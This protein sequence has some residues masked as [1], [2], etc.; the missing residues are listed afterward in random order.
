MNVVM[1]IV[2]VMVVVDVVWKKV[3]CVKKK[4]GGCD[5]YRDK[6]ARKLKEKVGDE[7]KIKEEVVRRLI[8]VELLREMLEDGGGVDREE[9]GVGVGEDDGVIGKGIPVALH[10]AVSKE[11]IA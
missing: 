7:M 1:V 3:E 2:D 9:E 10:V 5:I 6:E 8:V 11:C 4:V